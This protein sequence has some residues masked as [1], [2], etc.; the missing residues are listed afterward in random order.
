MPLHT[1]SMPHRSLSQLQLQVSMQYLSQQGTTTATTENENMASQG[2]SWPNKRRKKG[3]KLTSRKI[4]FQHDWYLWLSNISVLSSVQDY[5]IQNL[6]TFL[7]EWNKSCQ[8]TAYCTQPIE[9]CLQY[10]KAFLPSKSYKIFLPNNSSAP[11]S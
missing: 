5:Q 4:Q 1:T 7:A 10:D 11:C 6:S 3:K 2:H 8:H 9:T